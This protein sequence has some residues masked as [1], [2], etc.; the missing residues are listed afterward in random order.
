M[1]AQRQKKDELTKFEIKV[2]SYLCYG[3]TVF[4]L[5][6]ILLVSY[7]KTSRWATMFLIVEF[8]FLAIGATFGFGSKHDA[9]VLDLRRFS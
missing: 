6:L 1:M 8:C 9:R 2:Y 3:T 7:A 5:L 4:S